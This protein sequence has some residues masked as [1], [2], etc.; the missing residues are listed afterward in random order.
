MFVSGD[1]DVFAA[2]RN[3]GVS[4]FAFSA[5]GRFLPKGTIGGGQARGV[6]TAPD[7]KRL[8]MTGAS[9]AIRQFDL[10]SGTEL[11]A[12]TLATRG[13]LHYLA[14]RKGQL[15]AAALDDGRVYRYDIQADDALSFV[16]AISVPSPIP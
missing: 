15:Y 7:G 3:G 16:D 14:I 13:N 6:A 2:N 10:E 1:G 4:H 11:A 8:Y 12:V 9:N 5:D